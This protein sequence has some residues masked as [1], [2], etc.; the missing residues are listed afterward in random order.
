M[1]YAHEVLKMDNRPLGLK[2]R[3][4]IIKTIIGME[5]KRCSKTKNQA[6]L[7]RVEG[8]RL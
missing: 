1:Q 2:N 4:Q 7:S 8:M 3:Q 6:D 5:T